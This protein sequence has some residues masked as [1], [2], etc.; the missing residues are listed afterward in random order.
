[1]RVTLTHPSEHTG[2]ARTL[3]QLCDDKTTGKSFEA[4]SP[5]LRL[6]RRALWPLRF[7]LSRV[8]RRCCAAAV[9]FQFFFAFEVYSIC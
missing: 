6:A 2:K 7:A 3:E 8:A 4:H 9:D 1:M 5:L